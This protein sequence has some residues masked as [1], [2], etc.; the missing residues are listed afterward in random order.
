MMQGLIENDAYNSDTVD[1]PAVFDMT[2][3]LVTKHEINLRYCTD[4][5]SLSEKMKIEN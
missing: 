5:R 3:F 4:F 2:M 1:R